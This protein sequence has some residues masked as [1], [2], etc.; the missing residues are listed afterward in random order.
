MRR[1]LFPAGFL[2]LFF[3]TP[4]LFPQGSDYAGA[5]LSAAVS[6]KIE[7][8]GFA[9]E[10][11][12]ATG[13][14]DGFPYTITVTF[15]A[16]LE[17]AQDSRQKI[18]TLVIAAV[19]DIS[20]IDSLIEFME[21]IGK[22]ERAITVR[23][24]L[25]ANDI[26]AVD[27]SWTLNGTRRFVETLEDTDSVCALLLMPETMLNDSSVRLV[28]VSTIPE[29]VTL[30]P[31]WLIKALPFKQLFPFFF[32]RLNLINADRRLSFFALN[33]IVSA[34][35]A[36][37]PAAQTAMYDGLI[38]FIDLISNPE[39]APPNSIDFSQTEGGSLSILNTRGTPDF[40]V[41]ERA[42]LGFFLLGITISAAFFCI[43]PSIFTAAAFVLLLFS[44]IDPSFLLPAASMSFFLILAQI[45]GNKIIKVI[46]ASFVPF[47]FL[48]CAMRIMFLPRDS[49]WVEK[50][51]VMP[52]DSANVSVEANHIVFIEHESVTIT[53]AAELPIIK[54]GIS[55]SAPDANPLYNSIFPVTIDEDFTARFE[56]EEYPPNPLVMQYLTT[57]DQDAV[58]TVD[59]F[60]DA[61]DGTIGTKRVQKELRGGSTN[62]AGG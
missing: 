57:K 48:F 59:F 28:P 43:F 26:S 12:F 21:T 35:I 14:K 24:V 32:Y 8:A 51:L 46:F 27:G 31:L 44:C 11:L 3:F 60:L 13:E 16:A 15:P 29:N 7:A 37:N 25:T 50:K 20:Y 40:F 42:Y 19:Q 56:L 52:L 53:A 58:L 47:I 10:F 6:S 9:Q 4:A 45:C 62:N 18:D 55:V 17:N 1:I 23:F 33:E 5:S 22:T 34:G 2:S 49:Q 54:C 39:A 41:R 30:T 61:G 38:Q 36:F